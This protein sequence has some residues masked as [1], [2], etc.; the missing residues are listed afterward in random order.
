MTPPSLREKVLRRVKT[1]ALK[2]YEH[3]KQQR[4]ALS[5]A[6]ANRASSAPHASSAP[7][8][9]D[10]ELPVVARMVIEIRSDG[11]R[12]VAR[13]AIQDTAGGEHVAIDARGSS[14]M[15]LAG[16]LAKS[17][18]AIPRSARQSL[19]AQ[20]S[21]PRVRVEPI[22]PVRQSWCQRHSYSIRRSSHPRRGRC[23]GRSTGGRRGHQRQRRRPDRREPPYHLQPV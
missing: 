20:A 18:F 23:R 10:D 13:G 14:P 22:G 11:R 9:T 21:V 1:A 7:L 15:E 12:T 2:R 8:A 16:T 17:I 19:R 5:S 4:D 6:L 3:A